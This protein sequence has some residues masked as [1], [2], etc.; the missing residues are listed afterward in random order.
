MIIAV[1]KI[2]FSKHNNSSFRRKNRV[3]NPI[4]I[5]IEIIHK[6]RCFLN[7][8]KPL[9]MNLTIKKWWIVF[10]LFVCPPNVPY[11]VAVFV[12][13][14]KTC[15]NGFDGGQLCWYNRKVMLEKMFQFTSTSNLQICVSV[16][17][18]NADLLP[19]SWYKL[20]KHVSF[21]FCY[22]TQI[23]WLHLV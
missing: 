13:L 3:S 22:L 11:I 21:S 10:C 18:R 2:D 7:Y 14:R 17:T 15:S 19:I 12:H 5:C 8:T 4:N 16:S 1:F 20:R 23:C 6:I 9:N